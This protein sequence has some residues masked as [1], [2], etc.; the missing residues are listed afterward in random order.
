MSKQVVNKEDAQEESF[1]MIALQESVISKDRHKQVEC[2]VCL[3]KMRSNNLKRHMLK[4][5]EIYTLDED[6]I[7]DE[8][9]R[10]KQLLL[11]TMEYREL[12]ELPKELK[13]R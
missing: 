11:E 7:R 5:R 12:L 2:K 8:I 3:R 9:K 4:H 6:V 10:P 1:E 13:S